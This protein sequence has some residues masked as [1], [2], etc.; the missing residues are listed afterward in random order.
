VGKK[1]AQVYPQY[2]GLNDTYDNIINSN[3]NALQL[4]VRQRMSYGLQ[5]MFNYTWGAAIDD[6]GTFRSGYLRIL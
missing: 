6:D 3:Y 1:C 2:S 4:V 5:F